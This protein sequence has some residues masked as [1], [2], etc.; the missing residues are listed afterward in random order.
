MNRSEKILTCC[1]VL[2]DTDIMTLSKKDDSEIKLKNRAVDKRNLA[3]LEKIVHEN[4]ETIRMTEGA[5][6]QITAVLPAYN[7]A[8]T[9]GRIIGQVKPF[10]NEIV[11]VD[12]GSTD[13]TAGI[14]TESGA[15]VIKH[16]KNVGYGSAL[17]SGFKYVKGNGTS[18]MVV[19]DADGQHDPAEIPRLTEPIIAGE[20]DIVIGSRFIDADQTAIPKYRRFGIGVVNKAWKIAGGEPVTDTQCGFRAYSRA[21]IDTIDIRESN[22]SASL[23]ILDEAEKHKLRL[24]EVP[25]SVKYGG[26]S[27]TMTPG[28]HGMELVNYVLRKL[29]DEHPLLIFG[30]GSLIFISAGLAFGV[31]SINSYFDSR[32]LPFGPTIIA[33]ILVYVGTLMMFGGLILNS[34]QSLAARLEQ[35]GL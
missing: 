28:K 14:A 35:K 6:W 32:Y 8:D 25:V 27:S 21:A 10:V 31:Y 34:I 3:V 22:M 16:P 29:K 15:M 19:L 1:V 17:A 33:A 26:Y 13:G 9:I 7:E 2:F 23:E 4:S 24:V 20:A 18:I 30:V 11:V 12:D 5:Q